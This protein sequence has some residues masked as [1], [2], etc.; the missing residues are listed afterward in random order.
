MR[1]TVKQNP[2]MKKA[3]TPMEKLTKMLDAQTRALIKLNKTLTEAQNQRA[4]ET[5]PS[6]SQSSSSSDSSNKK[7][8]SLSTNATK[9]FW[10]K[11]MDAG[12]ENLAL[13]AAFG[14][15]GVLLG[16]A[17]RASKI[18]PTAKA[19]L[20][21]AG[22]L[23]GKKGSSGGGNGNDGTTGA[24]AWN[25]AE[26][27]RA[28][29]IKLTKIT[30]KGFKDVLAAIGG[31]KPKGKKDE[32]SLLGKAWDWIKGLFG[33]AGKG[34]LG[35]LFGGLLKKAL[36]WLGGL[37]LAGGTAYALHKLGDKYFGEGGGTAAS[38]AGAGV[39]SRLGKSLSSYGAGLSAA[40]GAT[41]GAASAYGAAAKR[42]AGIDKALKGATGF[43]RG[44]LLATRQSARAAQGAA[45]TALKSAPKTTAATGAV[46]KMAS[47]LGKTGRI[48]GGAMVALEAGLGVYD[49]SKQ[50]AAG[51]VRGGNKTLTTTAGSVAGGWGGAKLGGLAGAKTG[52][53]LGTMFGPV[54]TLVGTVAGGLI[55]AA[56]GGF[57]G[58]KIGRWA[59]GKAYDAID[60]AEDNVAVSTGGYQTTLPSS[61]DVSQST[62][63]SQQNAILNTL[64]QIETNL[65]PETQRAVDNSYLNDIELRFASAPMPYSQMGDTDAFNLN[66]NSSV[67]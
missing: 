31:G 33:G 10:D 11:E 39:Y 34:L 65:R 8:S 19:G 58:S 51:D 62:M 24:V 9:D 41:K 37:A 44:T 42:V 16:K 30:E 14:P 49:A 20:K 4:I 12:I 7:S 1:V 22:T 13:S 40:R 29:L 47:G 66:I 59:S 21:M 43:Q 36:P 38:M 50:Y 61:S 54:G 28:P 52:A 3:E 45:L 6:D 32:K 23:F 57:A 35:R 48:A 17:W 64:K 5:L 26:M 25:E 15:A 63:I 53:M 67:R 2:E 18:W 46:G 56:L 27:A 55:G 60:P